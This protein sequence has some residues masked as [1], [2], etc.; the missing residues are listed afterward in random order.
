M[1]AFGE[2]CS[3]VVFECVG[4]E[5]L[6]CV[7]REILECV[8]REIFECVWRE[9]FECVWREIVC[10][11]TFSVSIFVLALACQTCREKG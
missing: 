4:R 3:D 11:V 1:D 9:I 5:I 2:T 8:W 10:Y 6:E 7:W